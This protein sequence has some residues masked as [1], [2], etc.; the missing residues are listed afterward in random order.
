MSLNVRAWIVFAGLA[1]LELSIS[2]A[3][4]ACP[5]HLQFLKSKCAQWQS[6]V[7]PTSLPAARG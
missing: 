4:A 2:R 3:A 7:L 5:E 1:A 6:A